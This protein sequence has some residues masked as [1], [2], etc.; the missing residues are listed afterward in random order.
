M[1]SYQGAELRN[2]SD[3]VQVKL[4]QDALK[5]VTRLDEKMRERLIKLFRIAG[6][7]GRPFTDLPVDC[8]I[9]VLNGVD[10]GQTLQSDK[11]CHNVCDCIGKEM[12]ARICKI[13]IESESKIS[14]L[15]D[16]ATSISKR[17]TLIILIKTCFSA[18][19]V[20]VM[21]GSHSGVAKKVQQAFSKCYS[22]A[23]FQPS[24]RISSW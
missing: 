7:T 14:V 2:F 17:S 12:R 5:N 4:K 20:S 8:D 6:K 23:L 9:N 13:I 10:I 3:A 22:M 18:D 16:E 1:K 15:S 11:S 24:L 21:F 19:S